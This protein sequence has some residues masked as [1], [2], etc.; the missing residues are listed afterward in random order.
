MHQ[1]YKDLLVLGEPRRWDENAVPRYCEFS[2]EACANIYAAEVVLLRIAC[3]ACQHRFEV[4]LSKDPVPTGSPGDWTLRA[5]IEAGA[6]HY[7]D[8]PNGCCTV[9]PA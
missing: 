5:C 9:G 2:P 7:G 3:Q 6:I 8:P 1:Y 4:A